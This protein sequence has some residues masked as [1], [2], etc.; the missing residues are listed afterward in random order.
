[1][2][3]KEKKIVRRVLIPVGIACLIVF[4]FGMAA[5]FL[6]GIG[7]AG[8]A[9]PMTDSYYAV[10]EARYAGNGIM[11]GGAMQKNAAMAP[12]MEAEAAMDSVVAETTAASAAA[13]S[14]S[15]STVG[16]I[17]APERKLIKNVSM[18][19]ETMEFDTLV[20]NISAKQTVSAIIADQ[21]NG[22]RR[23]LTSTSASF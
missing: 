13:S 6:F 12:A 19:I 20:S 1:M 4:V 23:P 5:S 18:G 10:D 15:G 7:R 17:P 11:A 8:S 2:E 3:N 22:Q 16:E 14:G 21:T 9:G